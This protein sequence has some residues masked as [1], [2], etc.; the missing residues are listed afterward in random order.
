MCG[1]VVVSVTQART[2]TANQVAEAAGVSAKTLSRWS[3]AGKVPEPYR[4]RR[5][6]RVFTEEDLRT[7]VRFATQLVAPPSRPRAHVPSPSFAGVT[8]ARSRAGMNRAHP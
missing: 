1:S 7:I 8:R 3:K 2:Y 6:W 5:G 4:D